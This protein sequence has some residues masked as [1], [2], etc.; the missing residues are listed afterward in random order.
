MTLK[1]HKT[2]QRWC[3]LITVIWN[4]VVQVQVQLG[5]PAMAIVPPVD[6][7]INEISICYFVI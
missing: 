1:E 3:T 5:D 7:H 6:Q 4:L 2:F